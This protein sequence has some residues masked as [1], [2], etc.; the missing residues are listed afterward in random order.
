LKISLL[1]SLSGKFVKCQHYLALHNMRVLVI[2]A[3]GFIG[4]AIARAA[5]VRGWQVRA[6]RRDGYRVGA[7][8]DLAT[9]GNIEWHQADLTDPGTIAQAMFGCDIVFHAAGYYPV[10]SRA[11]ANQIL[12]ARAQMDGVLMAFRQAK[13]DLLIY[14]SSLSTIAPPSQ[15]GRMANERDVYQL[16]RVPVLYYDV[17]IVMEQAALESGLPVVALCPTAVFGPGDVKPTSGRLILGVARGQVPFYTDGQ[18]NVVDVRDLADAH[19]TA[20]EQG[21]PGERYIVGGE[22]MS[23]RQ[24][25]IIMA[26]HAGRRPPW[27][28]LPV[29]LVEMAGVV[30]GQVGIMGADVIQGIRYFQPLDTRKARA[31]LSL[32]PRPFSDSVRSALAWFHENGYLRRLPAADVGASTSETQ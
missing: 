32:N 9:Q 4:G 13:P 16:G 6:V 29:R 30:A 26:R 31:E 5:V 15:P 2:G 10:T 23:Y 21:R 19:L 14:T 18:I 20:A 8:G 17:K 27:L 28:R 24:M 25:L 3:T 11:R 22:N 7:I 12:N 1:K